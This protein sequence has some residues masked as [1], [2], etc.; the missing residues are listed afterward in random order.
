MRTLTTSLIGLASLALAPTSFASDKAP[1]TI[2]FEQLNTLCKIGGNLEGCSKLSQKK[3]S[4]IGVITPSHGSLMLSPMRNADL[5]D[6][7]DQSLWYQSIQIMGTQYFRESI[8]ENM[9]KTVKFTGV[10]HTDCV[11]VADRIDRMRQDGELPVFI[12]GSCHYVHN[13]AFFDADI[14][15]TLDKP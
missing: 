10:L 9:G 1:E 14:E 3:I 13:R 11:E 6:T 15:V 4:I 8:T 5:E 2:S 7:D 12:S